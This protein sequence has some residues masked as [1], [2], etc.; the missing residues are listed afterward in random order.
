MDKKI[1]IVLVVFSFVLAVWLLYNFTESDRVVQE[2]VQKVKAKLGNVQV[3]LDNVQVVGLEF[4]CALEL[5]A[6]IYGQDPEKAISLCVKYNPIGLLPDDSLVR[7]ECK[8]LILGKL[9]SG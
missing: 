1:K 6:K 8:T 2:C 4:D 9:K 3:L 7:G 5:A